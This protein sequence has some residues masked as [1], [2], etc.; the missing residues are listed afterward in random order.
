MYSVFIMIEIVH[1][2]EDQARKT[3]VGVTYQSSSIG[4][5]EEF[6]IPGF[7]THLVIAPFLGEIRMG[8]YRDV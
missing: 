7:L 2:N 6:R 5:E 8:V 4:I 3:G 1:H